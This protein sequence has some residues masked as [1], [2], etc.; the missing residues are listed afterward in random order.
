MSYSWGL[1]TPT[2]F[3]WAKGQ[4]DIRI[5]AC[6]YSYVY[7]SRKTWASSHFS[8]KN[9]RIAN[10]FVDFGSAKH[11]EIDVRLICRATHSMSQGTNGHK[12]HACMYSYVYGSRKTWSCSLCPMMLTDFFSFPCFTPLI[13]DFRTK[14]LSCLPSPSISNPRFRYRSNISNT[15]REIRSPGTSSGIPGG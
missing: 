10:V 4:M 3:V 9:A 5:H 2:S 8:Q 15:C 13:Y 1:L 7:G 6:M 12:I 14:I 11:E